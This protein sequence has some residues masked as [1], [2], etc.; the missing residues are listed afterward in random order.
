VVATLEVPVTTVCCDGEET[1]ALA[2][3]EEFIMKTG[4]VCEGQ[5]DVVVGRKLEE[6]EE[7]RVTTKWEEVTKL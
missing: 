6:E 2:L 4:A 7:L 5:V 1:L 3:E